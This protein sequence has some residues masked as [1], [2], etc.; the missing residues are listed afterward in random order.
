[1]AATIAVAP[2]YTITS[3]TTATL[4]HGAAA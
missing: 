1:M 2:P 3:D 4:L